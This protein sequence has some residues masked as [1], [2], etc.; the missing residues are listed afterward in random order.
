MRLLAA[1][2]KQTL[3]LLTMMRGRLA[4]DDVIPGTAAAVYFSSSAAV[5]FPNQY[6]YHQ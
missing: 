3:S 1:H 2:L 4:D 5:Y 6:L